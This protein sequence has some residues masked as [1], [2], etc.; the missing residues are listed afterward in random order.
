[1]PTGQYSLVT[2]EGETVRAL[3]EPDY[4]QFYARRGGAD[5]A[6][7]TV[8]DEGY[9]AHLWTNGRFVYVGTRR[10]F[11]STPIA[12]TA[13]PFAPGDPDAEWQHVAE[14]SL[15]SGGSLDILN[16]DGDT[17]VVTMA[18]PAGDVRLRV[19]WQGLVAGRFEGLDEDGNSD[20]RLSFELW[21]AP[22]TPPTIVREWDGWPDWK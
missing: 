15:A 2:A 9:A 13:L 3:V 6:S 19:S 8:S 10:K 11:G 12:V 18:L 4:F 5:R 20:E 7:D 14:V 17:P 22:P 21:P 1:M 16:W